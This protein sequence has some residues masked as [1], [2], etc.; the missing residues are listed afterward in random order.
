MA[1]GLWSCNCN[2]TRLRFVI[3]DAIY[4]GQAFGLILCPVGFAGG[5][6][7]SDKVDAGIK[8]FAPCLLVTVGF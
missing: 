7:M 4:L 1:A 6:V 2:R 5:L 3:Y 8:D